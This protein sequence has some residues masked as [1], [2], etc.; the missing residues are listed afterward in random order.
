[1][2][3]R[4]KTQFACTGF[5]TFSTTESNFYVESKAKKW[6]G[7]FLAVAIRGLVVRG[8]HIGRDIQTFHTESL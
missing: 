1:M 3:S 8:F 6:K 7:A 5:S 2:E 4:S